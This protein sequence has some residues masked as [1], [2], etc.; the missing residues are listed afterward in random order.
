MVERLKKLVRST[1][2]ELLR[3]ILAFFIFLIL[4]KIV[5]NT[6]FSI[7]GDIIPSLIGTITLYCFKSVDRI[8]KTKDLIFANLVVIFVF[9][10][11]SFRFIQDILKNIGDN[12]KGYERN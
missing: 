7:S 12:I 2:E 6:G 1:V 8:E 11:L 3:Y 5:K 9:Y 10:S 4:N